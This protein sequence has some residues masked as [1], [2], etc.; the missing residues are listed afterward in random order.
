MPI[1]AVDV[2]TVKAQLAIL[3]QVAQDLGQWAEKGAPAGAPFSAH[4]PRS[5]ATCFR[6]ASCAFTVATSTA[7]I[8]MFCFFPVRRVGDQ[9]VLGDRYLAGIA[10]WDRVLELVG[11]VDPGTLR[12]DALE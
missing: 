8:G 5:C 9:L 6:I 7:T 4:C 3:K 2:A 10:T 12:L 1:V 11:A